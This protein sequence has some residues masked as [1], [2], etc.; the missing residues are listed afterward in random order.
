VELEEKK[1]EIFENEKVG[2][3]EHFRETRIIRRPIRNTKS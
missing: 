2:F 1:G 3:I